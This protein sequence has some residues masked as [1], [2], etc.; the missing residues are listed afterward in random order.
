M[1]PFDQTLRAL[2][3]ALSAFLT[4]ALA[5]P[6]LTVADEPGGFDFYVLAL[7]W[8]PTYCAQEGNPSEPQ[9]ALPASDFIV[10]GLWPQYE[11]GYPQYCESDR[12]NWVSRETIDAL[13]DIMPGGGLVGY[14]WRKHGLCA[15]LDEDEYFTLVRRAYDRVAMPEPLTELAEE[16][17]LSPQAIEGA[18]AEANKGL[19]I[20]AMSVQCRDGTFTEIRICLTK[21][22]EFR[23]CDEVDADRC[24][25]RTVTVPAAR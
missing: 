7:S 16:R 22:L 25:A 5:V 15:G 1:V 11:S 17:K 8:S 12:S 19:S 14:Q 10:H 23:S 20:D 4:G 2:V 18:F 21:G 24:R 13:R 3:S 9:C 6:A